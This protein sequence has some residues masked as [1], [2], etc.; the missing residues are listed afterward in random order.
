[1]DLLVEGRRLLVV[2][3]EQVLEG[4]VLENEGSASQPKQDGHAAAVEQRHED[5]VQGQGVVSVHLELRAHDV[6]VHLPLSLRRVGPAP[7]DAPEQRQRKQKQE[8]RGHHV[9]YPRIH[10]VVAHVRVPLSVQIRL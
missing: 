5:G 6:R 3:Q 4:V 1:M 9:D 7:S 8:V 10:D 2:A